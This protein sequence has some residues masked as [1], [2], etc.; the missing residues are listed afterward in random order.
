MHE[1]SLVKDI[2]ET[3]EQ[4]FPDR[5]GQL[6]DIQVSLGLLTA[7]QPLLLQSA[8]EAVQSEEP[9]YGHLRLHTRQLPIRIRCPHCGLESEVRN[10]HFYCPCGQACNH[11]IQGDE[12]LISEVSFAETPI[13][14]SS[15][16]PI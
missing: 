7:I 6:R 4:E 15:I 12:L 2:L 9:R 11:I 14:S 1:I 5:F 10:Y 8:F 16:T 3:L 13:P